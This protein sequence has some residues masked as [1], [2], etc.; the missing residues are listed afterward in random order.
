MEKDV[1]KK[2]EEIE[3][4]FK[5]KEIEIDRL[6]LSI[7]AFENVMKISREQI[8]VFESSIETVSRDVKAIYGTDNVVEQLGTLAHSILKI[9]KK[10]DLVLVD[11]AKVRNETSDIGLIKTVLTNYCLIK[12]SRRDEFLEKIV[13][14]LEHEEEVK[15]E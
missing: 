3:N 4:N 1:L 2:F 12:K 7:A 6:K 15:E 9:G 10:L 8:K 5:E 11:F 14:K 13:P